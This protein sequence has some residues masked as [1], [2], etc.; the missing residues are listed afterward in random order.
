MGFVGDQFSMSVIRIMRP[1]MWTAVGVASRARAH[2]LNDSDVIASQVSALT[3]DRNTHACP[4]C[5]FCPALARSHGASTLIDDNA[6]QSNAVSFINL[7]VG[8]RVAKKRAASP[9][10]FQSPALPAAGPARTT[11][12][13]HDRM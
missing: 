2:S 3:S 9:W 7:Q 6:V 1:I 5:L 12:H 11:N 8:Y 10:M 13:I 4:V